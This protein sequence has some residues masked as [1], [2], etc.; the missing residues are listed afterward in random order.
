MFRYFVDAA[1]GVTACL[2]CALG[3]PEDDLATHCG[4]GDT[5]SL[6]RLFHYFPYTAADNVA[7]VADAAAGA[8]RIGSSPHTDWGWL[9]L[10]LQQGDVVGLQVHRHGEWH[11]VA[12]V[13]G[14]LTTN[15][16]DYVSLLTAG[17]FHSPLHR[18]VT[19]DAERTSWV[20][21]SYPD[22]EARI[23]AVEDAA[24]SYSLFTDQRTP[25]QRS[26]AAAGGGSPA[27]GDAE[28]EVGDLSFGEFIRQK[29][30]SVSRSV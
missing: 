18:V 23:P 16:G 30:A 26:A 10:I 13:P 21:F 8:G 5:I 19:G 6:M 28:S 15:I 9:T 3:L 22:F 27:S 2:S 12:P 11:D 14:A 20:F 25:A 24:G 17:K 7:Q 29:W 4:E 1:H